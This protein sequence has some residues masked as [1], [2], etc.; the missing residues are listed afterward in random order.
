[1]F[2]LMNLGRCTTLIFVIAAS[3]TAAVIATPLHFEKRGVS[4]GGSSLLNAML[5]VRS[6]HQSYNDLDNWNTTL[7]QTVFSREL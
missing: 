2:N 5:Y 1:M 7:K 6:N 4:M 3:N